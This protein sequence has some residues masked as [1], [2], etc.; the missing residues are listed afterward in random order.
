VK[1]AATALFIL[2]FIS[3]SLWAQEEVTPGVRPELTWE[4][5]EPPPP[6][7]K[8]RFAMKNRIF[9]ISLVNP[10]L[11]FSN[12][13]LAASN[14]IRSPGD[15]IQTGKFFKDS[16]S[17][18]LNEFFRGFTFKFDAVIEP[19][20]LNFN[21][22]N[23]WGFGL[24]IGHINVTGNL[25][26][27]GNLLSFNEVNDDKFGVGAAVFINFGIPVF[28]HYNEVKI[29]IRPSVFLPVVYTEPDITYSYRL[30]PN[31]DGISGMRFQVDYD[32]R[33]YSIVNMQ[34][35]V[36][37]DWGA[38]FQDLLDNAW[39]IARNNLGY[40]FS[41]GVEYPWYNWLDIGVDFINIPLVMSNLNHYKQIEGRA[42]F[43][44]S[45]IDI[46]GIDIPDIDISDLFKPG[47]V[48]GYLNTIGDG[49][50]SK[51]IYRPF[52]TLFYARWRPFESLP[53]FSLI[54]S[55][56]FSVSRLYTK[57]GSIEGGLSVRF[58][59][60]NIFIT[61][62]GINY[63][64]RKWKNSID[65]VLLNLRALEIDFGISFQSS[66]FVKSFQGAGFGLNIG[67][68]FGW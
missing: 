46:D 47:V 38:I 11:G 49:N 39:G 9:E 26:L 58:D 40:D 48:Y 52:T 28:F 34:G 23:K 31:P 54:P 56:G 29:K 3:L 68:R 62:I 67:L 66:N 6:P 2:F 1:K 20:S 25:L 13:F 35:F 44:T 50:G 21:W 45:K 30:A 7:P 4:E 27:S 33:V 53:G 37:N 63:N 57:L 36:K 17:I 61:T 43:D 24:D 65:F 51:K 5:E 16:V 22:K 15:M 14:V 12:S 60:A 59:L 19:I 8:K 18:N 42:F 55:L 41:I 64:D 32:V 10:D